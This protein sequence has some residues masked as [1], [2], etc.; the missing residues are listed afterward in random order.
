MKELV[1]EAGGNHVKWVFYGTPAAGNG[2]LGV[3]EMGCSAICVCEDAHHKEHFLKALEQ[4]AVEQFLL[5]SSNVFGDADLLAKAQ[6][7]IPRS[8]PKKK[9]KEDNKD[10]EEE[11]KDKKEG[12]ETK[13]SKNKQRSE[14]DTPD[15]DEKNKTKKKKKKAKKTASGAPKKEKK[16]EKETQKAAGE[17]SDSE[18]S[19][20]DDS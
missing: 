16:N 10:K 6:K 5:G 18:D 12:K 2:V 4:K 3:L 14:D 19:A 13:S 11:G 15:E 9:A 1:W 20:T 17:D 8:E 7:Y